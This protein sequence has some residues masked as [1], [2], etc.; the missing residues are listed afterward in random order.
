[1]FL[2][3]CSKGFLDDGHEPDYFFNDASMTESFGAE[4]GP[5]PLPVIGGLGK[6]PT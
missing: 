4:L 6:E 2:L 3:H 1:M 5:L